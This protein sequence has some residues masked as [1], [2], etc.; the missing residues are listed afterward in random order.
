M[1]ANADSLR[2]TAS[3]R[4]RK[5]TEIRDTL[6]RGHRANE[7]PLRVHVHACGGSCHRLGLSVSRRVGG[8]VRRNRM[9]RLLREAFRADRQAWD[10]PANIMV[11]VQPHTLLN[12]D[13]Y[14]LHLSNAV[15]HALR[16]KGD[17]T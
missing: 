14:R 3:M 17:C 16:G 8:A 1:T 9:K 6:R 7:G 2:L 12:L 4:L 5:P 13:Q 15:Q 10:P 11:I